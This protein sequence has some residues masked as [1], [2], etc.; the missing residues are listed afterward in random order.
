[1]AIHAVYTERAKRAAWRTERKRGRAC[2]NACST[3]LEPLASAAEDLDGAVSH[4]WW[5]SADI[6]GC[7]RR[8]TTSSIGGYGRSVA[9]EFNLCTCK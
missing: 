7:R 5:C 6:D 2:G 9:T 4:Q 1:M 3:E 8:T